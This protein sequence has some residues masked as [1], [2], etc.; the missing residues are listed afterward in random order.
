MKST[1]HSKVSCM[2]LRYQE[3]YTINKV[4]VLEKRSVRQTYLFLFQ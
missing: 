4:P 2:H 1:A 3:L